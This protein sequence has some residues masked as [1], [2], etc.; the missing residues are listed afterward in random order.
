M[1]VDVQRQQKL[2]VTTERVLWHYDNT[3][4]FTKQSGVD[5]GSAHIFQ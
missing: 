2:L 4:L 3:F 5:F 1:M